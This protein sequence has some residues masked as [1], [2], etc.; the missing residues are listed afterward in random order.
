VRPIVAEAAV[1][2]QD[3]EIQVESQG[4]GQELVF[5]FP[6]EV[7]GTRAIALRRAEAKLRAIWEI[8]E[9]ARHVQAHIIQP[10]RVLA[11]QSMPANHSMPVAASWLLS[12]RLNSVCRPADFSASVLLPHEEYRTGR[13]WALP[14][15]SVQLL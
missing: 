5:P 15:R 3:T 1:A 14:A 4:E 7:G 8:G 11:N 9:A 6:V 13:D 12:A 2:L 10:G